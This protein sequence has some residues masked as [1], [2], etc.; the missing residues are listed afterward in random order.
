MNERD[1]MDTDNDEALT[2]RSKQL[3]DAT[4]E[5]LDAATCSRLNRARHAALAEARPRSG[6]STLT[7]W[8]P[9]AGVAAAAVF[10]VVLWSETSIDEPFIQQ[11]IQQASASD[12]EI[13]LD[14]DNLEML[15]DLEFY[16]WI[17]LEAAVDDVTEEGSNVG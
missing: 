1:E 7:P 5:S 4:A 11:A 10:A 14:D 2:E 17:D 12:F 8:V 9:A 15:S 6:F 13:L 3:F 16:S